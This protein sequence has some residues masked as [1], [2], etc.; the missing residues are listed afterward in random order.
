MLAFKDYS[1]PAGPAE[2]QPVTSFN[3]KRPGLA[4]LIRLSAALSLGLAIP[5]AAANV[6]LNASDAMGTSSFDAVGHWNNSAAPAAGNSYF[7]GSY[8]LRIPADTLARTFA[9]DALTLDAGGRVLGKTTGTSQV[10]TVNNFILNGGNFEQATAASDNHIL[11][12]AGN[13][14]VIAPSGLGALGG[15]A[16]GSASFETLDITAAI[17]G[18]AAL[19]LGGPSLNAGADSG[20]VELSAANSYGGTLTVSGGVIASAVNRLLQLNNLNALSNA[21]LNLNSTVANPV[22]FVAGVNTGPFRVGQLSGT[23][24]QALT[25]T[26]GAAVMLSVGGNNGSSV[27]SGALTGAGALA[28]TGSGI[29]TLAGANT[30]A[31]GTTISGGTLQTA[32]LWGTYSGSGKLVLM[33]SS[34]LVPQTV[35]AMRGSFTG[36]WVIAGGRLAAAGVGALGT[37]GITVDPH[38]PLGPTAAGVSVAN[39]ALFEPQYD[40]NSAGTLMLTNGGKMV[41]HQNCAFSAVIIEGVSLT[42]GIYSWQDLAT[43]FPANVTPTGGGYIAV[44]PYGPLP[45]FPAQAPR[46]LE[47][48][49]SQ[50]NFTGL[51]GELGALVYGNPAPTFQWQYA[52]GGSSVF[53]NLVAGGQFA[54]VTSPTLTIAS[55]TLANAGSYVLVA[56]NSSGSVTSA[57]A[58]L[59]VTGPAVLTNGLGLAI[60]MAA[61]GNYTINSTDPA[62]SFTGSLGATPANVAT[63]TGKDRIGNY[64]EFQFQ[65]AASVPHLAGI[66]LYTNQ[67]V[68]LFT[69][70][71]L[72][73]SPNDLAFPHFTSYPANLYHES[74][75]SSAFAPNTFSQLV[76]ESPW[77]FFNTN[78]DCF[79]LSPATNYMIA[80]DVL[81]GDGSIS[82]GIQS[83]IPELPAG[84]THRTILTIQN[85]I[86]QAFE[87]W[88]NALTGL[89]GKVRPANDSTVELNKLGYWTD[90]GAAYYYSYVPSLGYTGTLL[91]VRDQFATNGFPLGY[92]QLD[93][94]WYPKGAANT[95]QGDSFNNRGGI[96]LYQADSALFPKGLTGFQGQLG[97]PLI[98]HCRWIDGASPYRS[99]YA[100]SANVIVDDAYWTNRMAY[101]SAAGVI[102]FEHD[103]LD[104]NALPLLNLTDPPAFMNEMADSAAACGINMQYCM[105]LPRHYLQGSLYDNL[106]TM[107]VSGDRFEIGKWNKLLYTS[108]LAGAVGCWPWARSSS[109]ASRPSCIRA[110]P[111]RARGRRRQWPR[112]GSA[113]C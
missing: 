21:T 30:Y 89:S 20:V 83:G 92:L 76:S 44:Q 84:F 33:A 81:N 35:S 17:R 110:S 7:T 61:D 64:T 75:S 11:T 34:A 105:A 39:T 27:Y 5:A 59:M 68:V 69:D 9:G 47:Q 98:T 13:I 8:V 60:S 31:G 57:P 37:N 86:N 79:I 97:L 90:N 24:N 56:S 73:D 111:S 23:A 104:I 112:A 32:R 107:R 4:R 53:T 80:G 93:S 87:T 48:P 28:K 43:R 67:P 1:R 91:A 14:N 12:W 85:G 18:S 25:D 74:F 108:Q 45:A 38:Y 66:R 15:L 52:A 22:A 101:L 16:N 50:T 55:L 46:F 19:Q 95:W 65:C 70:T 3:A 78:F 26:A 113:Q 71:T 88:G 62:W 10:I 49:A 72:A 42:N 94:W 58:I 51:N 82:C 100:M 77:I 41:L 29:L 102:T 2:S 54:G 106:V 109:I 6:S 36:R 40:L 103:W 96:N 63:V 99:Q